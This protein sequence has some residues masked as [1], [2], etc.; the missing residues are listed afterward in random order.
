MRTTT[1]PPA[2]LRQPPDPQMVETLLTHVAAT[3]NIDDP[4]ILNETRD[5][6]GKYQA[7]LVAQLVEAISDETLPYNVS[8]LIS[9][10]EDSNYI[11]EALC[12]YPHIKTKSAYLADVFLK[13]LRHYPQLPNV[14]DYSSADELTRK[15]CIAIMIATD[16]IHSRMAIRDRVSFL[17]PK[18]SPA[19]DAVQMI[20]GNGL[21]ELLMDK[22]DDAHRI[23]E[24]IVTRATGDAE[25]IKSI[26]NHETPVLADGIL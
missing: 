1:N 3:T 22:P 2:P 9:Y 14:P 19:G 24:I 25:L 17:T 16:I 21:V 12:F 23:A 7:D 5:I 20:T 4:G 6:I 10:G 11:R 26:L 18:H 8:V 15:Q 13:S